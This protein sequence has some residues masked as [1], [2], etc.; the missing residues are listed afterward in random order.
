MIPAN[1]SV[2]PRH[3]VVMG[4]SAVGK[5]TVASGLAE[6]LG[7]TFLDA[8]DLHPAANRNKMASGTPLTDDDRW[9]WLAVVGNTMIAR[10]D[11]IVVA[12][13]ALKRA[14]RDR[15]RDTAPEAFFVFLDGSAELLHARAIA[16][17]AHFMPP[18]LLESQ[19]ATLEP[20][21]P[22][23]RGVRIGVEPPPHVV[24]DRA[25]VAVKE[26]TR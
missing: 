9:P 2:F 17:T 8:D 23:E 26:G 4:V 21:E 16:R 13:S 15:I 1:G 18:A 7:L 3:I 14:Y 19:L 5:S 11:G 22:D 25:V 10:P 6:A 20:L 12:C 24:V